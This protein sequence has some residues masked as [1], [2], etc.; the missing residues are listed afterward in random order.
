MKSKIYFKYDANIVGTIFILFQNIP[1]T[2]YYRSS[3]FTVLEGGKS[4][5]DGDYVQE[6]FTHF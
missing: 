2:N 5:K 1:R 3:F 4:G 6:N